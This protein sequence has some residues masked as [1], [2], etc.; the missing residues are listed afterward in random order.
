MYMSIIAQLK[1]MYISIIAQL[2]IKGGV[3]AFG[4][5]NRPQTL[6]VMQSFFLSILGQDQGVQMSS[7]IALYKKETGTV[8]VYDHAIL[9]IQSKWCACSSYR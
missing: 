4:G 7:S 6:K 3:L 5:Y 8:V 9:N 2:K 1:I